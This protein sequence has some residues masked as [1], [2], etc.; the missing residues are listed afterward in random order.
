MKINNIVVLVEP[1]VVDCDSLDVVFTMD[2]SGSV[3][4]DNY[5]EIKSFLSHFVTNLDIDSGSAR[6]GV[7]TYSAK[8]NEVIY[9]N[10][11]STVASLQAAIS[12][13]SYTGGGTKTGE[14]LEYVRKK[15]LRES[16]GDR[17]DVPNVIVILTD[18][19]SYKASNT[20]VCAL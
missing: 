10:S 5:E 15:I 3:G 4:K 16:R 7:V 2:E 13:L 18:G 8:V 1:V 9:L 14:V 11:H 20:E 19:K 12:S 17:I 6:V